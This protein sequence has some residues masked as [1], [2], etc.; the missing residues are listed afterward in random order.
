MKSIQRASTVAV[1]VGNVTIGGNHPIVVQSMTNTETADV[2]ATTNQIKSL[3]TAGSELVR[4][5]VNSAQA[6]QAVPEIYAK[7][8]SDKCHVTQI[9]LERVDRV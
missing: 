9:N 8:K 7:L 4:I 1:S 2:D 5:T 6:A 3:V